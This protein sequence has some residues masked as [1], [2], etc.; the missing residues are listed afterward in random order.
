MTLTNSKYTFDTIYVK[1]KFIF[2]QRVF[3]R[4]KKIVRTKKKRTALLNKQ[5][6]IQ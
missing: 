2:K 5:F 4:I 3:K 1:K 6:E